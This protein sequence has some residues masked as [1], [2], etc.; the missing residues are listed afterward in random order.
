[1]GSFGSL[2]WLGLLGSAGCGGARSGI[3]QSSA[4]SPGRVIT[5]DAIAASGAKTAWDAVGLVVP[6]VQLREVRGQPARIQRRGRASIYLDDQVRVIL[7]H[8]PIDDLQVL[9]QVAATDILTIEILTGLDATTYYGASSTSGVI[10]I[11]TT[12]G[13]P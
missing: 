12:S 4:P 8:V 5:A 9:K 13:R 1:L 2:A 11:T 3:E 7:D 6:N 10:V